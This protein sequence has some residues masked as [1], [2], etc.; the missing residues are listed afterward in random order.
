MIKSFIINIFKLI[1]ILLSFWFI[2]NKI[3][4]NLDWFLELNFGFGKII[5]IFFAITIY[6]LS[7]F[8]LSLAW[9]NLLLICGHKNISKNTC[10]LIYGKTQIAKYI[11]GNV[12]HFVGRH[13]LGLK[14]GINSAVL[15]GSAIYE[16]LGLI[17]SSL[18]IGLGIVIFDLGTIYFLSIK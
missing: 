11:P 15:T 9:R 13:L 7:Q 12:F 6:S 16:I 10:N 4:L 18:V 5:L 14:E 3:Y 1:V 17:S 8:I 2:G